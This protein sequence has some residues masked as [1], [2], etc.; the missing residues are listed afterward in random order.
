MEPG[1]SSRRRD[2]GNLLSRP[3]PKCEGD[4]FWVPAGQSVTIDGR[5][6]GGMVYFGSG[7]KP[8]SS[9]RTGSEPALLDPGRKVSWSKPDSLGR[10][11]P[12]WPSYCEMDP[13]CR[14]A[15]LQWLIQGRQ[16]PAASIGY[17]FLFF[18]GI[19]RRV[20]VD[21]QI[22]DRAR[23]EIDGLLAEV[24]RLLQIYGGNPSFRGYAGSF[25]GSARFL[26]RRIDPATLRPPRSRAGWSIPLSLKLGLGLSPP[27]GRRSPRSGPIPGCSTFPR[28]AS[29]TPAQRCPEEFEEL[30]RI[31]YRKRSR[32]GGLQ[33]VPAGSPDRVGLR[34]REPQLRTVPSLSVH[35]SCPRSRSSAAPCASSRRSPTRPSRSST[36]TAAGWAAPA[37]RSPAAVALLRRSWREGG[38]TRRTSGSPSGWRAGWHRDRASVAGTA[39]VEVAGQ[40]EREGLQARRRGAGRLPRPARVRPGAGRPLRRPV[41]GERP[42]GNLPAGRGRRPAEPGAAYH[43]AAVLLQLAATVSAADG[44]VSRP[45]SAICSRISRGRSICPRRSACGSRPTC[46]GCWLR[47]RA[48]RGSRRRVGPLGET[49]RREI[50]QFLIAVAGADG[51]VGAEE[52]KLLPRI[53]RLLGLEAQAVYS[54]VHAWR[55]PRRRPRPSR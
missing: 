33:V 2:H 35:W 1:F 45:R 5:Q 34:T 36:S 51:H 53:Y 9:F 31:R 30:F 18:Y 44:E 24:E 38:R 23:A 12:Y 8:V 13:A 37:T 52:L 54:D 17:V 25:L 6:I 14:G 15:Y 28:S 49:Q 27:R 3:S 22:S 11:L 32:L 48:S 29:R 40:D 46:A 21:A 47:R 10:L 4:R 39:F 7:L 41:P 26:H 55:A 42:G 43:A 16:D 50:G 19:E 20:L